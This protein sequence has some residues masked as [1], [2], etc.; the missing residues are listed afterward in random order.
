[1]HLA[2]NILKIGDKT[3]G[4][5]LAW[6]LIKTIGAFDLLIALIA[7]CLTIAANYS[8]LSLIKQF[9]EA[10]DENYTPSQKSYSLVGAVI[11]SYAT[12]AVCTRHILK[13][14][15]LTPA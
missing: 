10:L 13:Q 2:N 11:L 5:L 12:F 4:L 8:Q 7:N 3:S 15:I 1:M 14:P 6:S 9:I